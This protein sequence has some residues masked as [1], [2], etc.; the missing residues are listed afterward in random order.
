MQHLCLLVVLSFPSLLG[1]FT[2]R[3]L[4]LGMG[5]Q[6]KYNFVRFVRFCNLLSFSVHFCPFLSDSACF[7]LFLSVSVRFCP[8]LSVLVRFCLFLSVLSV[9]I[10]FCPFL[11]VSLR[12]CPF[13]SVF[14]C[15]GFFLSLWG[16]LSIG[17][18]TRKRDVFLEFHVFS[19]FFLIFLG[20][21]CFFL[22]CE[23]FDTW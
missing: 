5:K 4:A 2:Q 16:F 1:I 6:C 23:I 9:S 12:F 3:Y 14:V 11:S 20:F 7:C 15:F 8:I 19:L 10:C 13:L 22:L 17:A 18:T 21:S